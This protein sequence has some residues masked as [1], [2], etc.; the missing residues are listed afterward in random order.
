MI[1]GILC[2]VLKQRINM[3]QTYD[4]I[5]L[6]YLLFP[7]YNKETPT[8]QICT[9]A[10]QVIFSRKFLVEGLLCARNIALY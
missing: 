2:I 5:K 9:C 1:M 10:M 3:I 6:W 7:F 8:K 4:G